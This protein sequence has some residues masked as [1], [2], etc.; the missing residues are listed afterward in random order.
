MISWG[1]AVGRRVNGEIVL[2]VMFVVAVGVM[3][4]KDG[5]SKDCVGV[6]RAQQ[7]ER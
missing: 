1:V 6:A 2:V 3:V 7:R 4:G 5:W